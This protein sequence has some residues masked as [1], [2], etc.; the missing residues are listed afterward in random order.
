MHLC[1][2][3]LL[4]LGDKGP[5][6]SLGRHNGKIGNLQGNLLLRKPPVHVFGSC[7]CV[8]A[9]MPSSVHALVITPA[10]CARFPLRSRAG[11]QP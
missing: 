3:A 7:H 2:V 11:M 5:W 9:V 8:L 6:Q 10:R 4:I 1:H